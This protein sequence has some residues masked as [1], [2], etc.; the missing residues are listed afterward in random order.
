MHAHTILHLTL[1]SGCRRLTEAEA[2]AAGV[3]LSANYVPGCAWPGP[4]GGNK[5]DRDCLHP[6]N[7]DIVAAIATN[8][9]IERAYTYLTPASFFSLCIYDTSR[10]DV[11]VLAD[12]GAVEG[13]YIDVVDKE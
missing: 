8:V 4:L 5:S 10:L 6:R 13:N 2:A 1:M 12:T 9:S 3:D 11:E 7:Q